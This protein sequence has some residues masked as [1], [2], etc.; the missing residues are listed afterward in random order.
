MLVAK[1]RASREHEVISMERRKKFGKA[2]VPK[3][4]CRGT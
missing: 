3:L 4:P 1:M 2:M